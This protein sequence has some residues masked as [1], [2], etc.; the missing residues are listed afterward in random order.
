MADAH[1]KVQVERDHLKKLANARRT[2]QRQR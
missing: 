2:H 1:F